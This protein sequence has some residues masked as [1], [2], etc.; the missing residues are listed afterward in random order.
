MGSLSGGRLPDRDPPRHRPPWTE[1]PWT[2]TTC[3]QRPPVNRDL[4][5]RDPQ[6]RD[7]QDR[8]PRL[9][10]PPWTETPCTVKIGRYASYSNAFLFYFAKLYHLLHIGRKLWKAFSWLIIKAVMLANRNKYSRRFPILNKITH[11][12]LLSSWWWWNDSLFFFQKRVSV[13]LNELEN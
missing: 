7:P 8:D 10:R 13:D 5:D 4:L 9:Q 11:S 2:E 3:G 12:G 1:T 6:D